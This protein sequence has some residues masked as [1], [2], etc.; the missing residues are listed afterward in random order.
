MPNW[1]LMETHNVVDFGAPAYNFNVEQNGK[2]QQQTSTGTPAARNQT[3][4]CIHTNVRTCKHTH[5]CIH[6]KHGRVV[7]VKSLAPRA[8]CGYAPPG[9]HAKC[10]PLAGKGFVAIARFSCS[11]FSPLVLISL[12]A[13]QRP[14]AKCN[15]GFVVCYRLPR[16]P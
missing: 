11:T 5:E 7:A 4:T 6:A 13:H 10:V 9:E 12:G 1:A 2:P 14:C 15:R 3:C 8:V 16:V